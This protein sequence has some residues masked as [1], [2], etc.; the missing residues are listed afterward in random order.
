MKEV[1]EEVVYD[2]EVAVGSKL[3]SGTI[4]WVDGKGGGIVLGPLLYRKE[5]LE[6]RRTAFFRMHHASG[7]V[8][9]STDSYKEWAVPS[10]VEFEKI[11]EGIREI[12]PSNDH[13]Y[14]LQGT[15]TAKGVVGRVRG[16]KVL[17]GPSS[18]FSGENYKYR[19]RKIFT[20][21]SLSDLDEEE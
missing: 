3:K 4:V 10:G 18:V 8:A 21:E 17:E 9:A 2:T 14:W 1:V 12:E 6:L 20:F 19:I 13:K 15:G 16:D 7:I 11:R 5:G